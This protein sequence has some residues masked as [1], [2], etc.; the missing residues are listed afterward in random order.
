M[1]VFEEEMSDRPE[2]SSDIIN[3]DPYED[4]PKIVYLDEKPKV[5]KFTGK[6]FVRRD[7]IN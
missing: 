6:R 4:L 1:E 5:T 7:S 3:Y 2:P